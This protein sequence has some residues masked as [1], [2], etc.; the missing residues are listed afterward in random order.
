MTTP[1]YLYKYQTLSAYSLASLTNNTIWMAKPTTF[2]DPFDCALTLDRAKYTESVMHA[3]SVAME[4]AKTEGLKPE[5]LRDIW[6]GDAEAFEDLRGKLLGLVQ[7]M[8]ICSFS[9]VPNHLLMWSHYANHHR[10]FCV[11]YDCREGTLLRKKACKVRY[12]D[13]VPSLSAADFS[14]QNSNEAFDVLWLTKAKY[15]SYEEEWRVMMPEGN[16]TFQAP[17]AITAVI[18]GARMPESD[19]VMITHALRHEE[20]IQFKEAVLKESQFLIEIV[21]V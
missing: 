20:N 11:G 12:E 5:H 18:F 9:A 10:G 6:P 13:T 14:P 21:D 2:N 19:R 1:D 16:K 8:G 3:I 4:R 17:S 15:W 7:T